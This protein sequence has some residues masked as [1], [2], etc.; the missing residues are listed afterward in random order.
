MLT[1]YLKKKINKLLWFRKVIKDGG[2]LCWL[3]LKS[4]QIK[5]IIMLWMTNLV[6]F[7]TKINKFLSS[8]STENKN[9]PYYGEQSQT[10]NIGYVCESR[11]K[12]WV[13][14]IKL[15]L[16]CLFMIMSFNY[17]VPHAIFYIL[18]FIQVQF[19]LCHTN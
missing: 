2:Y 1:C 6:S 4:N 11:L 3:Y 17:F 8:N 9:L 16:I 12:I 13:S 7:Q 15:F 10:S 18:Y 14:N 19:N 5:W